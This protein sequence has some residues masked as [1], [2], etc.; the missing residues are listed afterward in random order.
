MT[1]GLPR[2]YR[3]SVL[4]RPSYPTHTRPQKSRAYTRTRL[5]PTRAD[6]PYGSFPRGHHEVAP[7][8]GV[9]PEPERRKIRTALRRVLPWTAALAAP[10]LLVAISMAPAPREADIQPSPTPTP[11]TSEV[12][13]KVAPSVV[14]IKALSSDGKLGSGSGVVIDDAGDILTALHVVQ[15]AAR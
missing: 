13:A 6:R 9:Q 7:D 3:T 11:L 15:A 4:R 12:Y 2:E 1:S 8:P 14:Q 5:V 10:A